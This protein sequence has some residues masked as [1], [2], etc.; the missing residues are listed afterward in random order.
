MAISAV[1]PSSASWPAD[2]YSA[3][4]DVLPPGSLVAFCTTIIESRCTP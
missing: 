2:A 1:H 4:N 3:L